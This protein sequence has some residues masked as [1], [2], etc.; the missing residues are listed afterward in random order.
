[1]KKIIAL[2]ALVLAIGATAAIVAPS[3]AQAA[4]T[5]SIANVSNLTRVDSNTISV[6]YDFKCDVN[7]KFD[8]DLEYYSGPTLGWLIADCGGSGSRVNCNHWYPGPTSDYSANTEHSGTQT[9][10]LHTTGA[11]EVPDCGYA[12]I[13][14]GGA[15][16]NNSNQIA[17]DS[18][19]ELLA[20]C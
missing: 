11:N 9:F 15:F 4:G 3:A 12:W 10:Q 18:S 2:F 7:Y 1:M 20:T 19:N 8:I 6:H 14:G 5:C 13:S 16:D 17:F